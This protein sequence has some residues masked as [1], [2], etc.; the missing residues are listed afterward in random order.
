MK[1]GLWMI[2]MSENTNVETPRT[3]GETL[4]QS[5]KTNKSQDH[6]FKMF[7]T[8]SKEELAMY[9]HQTVCSPP[10]TTFL[11]SIQ[12]NQFNSFPGITYDLIVQHLPPSK[13]AAQGHMAKLRE[14]I[15]STR[16][17]RQ[18]ILDM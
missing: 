12:N 9:Y 8:S 2:P 3:A 11:N 16:S 13:V 5:I 14:G 6:L 7:E 4:H 15:R 18:D 1:T 17:N 10:K